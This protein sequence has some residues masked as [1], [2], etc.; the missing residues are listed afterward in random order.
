MLLKAGEDFAPTI[1]VIPA[2]SQGVIYINS[3]VYYLYVY[4]DA[5]QVIQLN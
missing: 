5:I 1:H 4:V 3:F 2:L